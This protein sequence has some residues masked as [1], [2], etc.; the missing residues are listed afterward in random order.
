MYICTQLSYITLLYHNNN[1]HAQLIRPVRQRRVTWGHGSDTYAV[2]ISPQPTQGGL[3]G[4]LPRKIW[5]FR[6]F[7]GN[8]EAF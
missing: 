5:K 6:L 7:E 2:G 1:A 8:S 3:G 4:M